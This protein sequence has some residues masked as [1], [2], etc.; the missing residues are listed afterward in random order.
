MIVLCF[1]KG[2]L[3]V[4]RPPSASFIG[5]DNASFSVVIIGAAAPKT[6]TLTSSEIERLVLSPTFR[7]EASFVSCRA[8]LSIVVCG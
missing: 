7:E 8:L 6:D 4:Q 5:V 2:N 1:D 3:I